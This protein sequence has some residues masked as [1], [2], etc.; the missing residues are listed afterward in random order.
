MGEFSLQTDAN[1]LLSDDEYKTHLPVVWGMIL[2]TFREERRAF[3]PQG[4]RIPDDTGM[5]NAH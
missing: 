4:L 3:S 2:L 5:L 1:L